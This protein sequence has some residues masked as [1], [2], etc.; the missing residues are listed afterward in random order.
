M[1]KIMLLGAFVF[2]AFTLA[3][4]TMPS[5]AVMAWEEARHSSMAHTDVAKSDDGFGSHCRVIQLDTIEIVG[6][7]P[8]DEVL[9]QHAEYTIGTATFVEDG[10]TVIYATR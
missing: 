3:S 7:V 5:P 2:A 6:R 9:R 1:T 8:T 10:K 4:V